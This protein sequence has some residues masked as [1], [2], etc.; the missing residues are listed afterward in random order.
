MTHRPTTGA[1]NRSPSPVIC[2]TRRSSGV[3]MRHRR[4]PPARVDQPARRPG[5]AVAASRA[6]DVDVPGQREA[7]ERTALDAVLLAAGGADEAK[8]CRAASPDRDDE[9]E[10]L[11]AS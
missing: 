7:D 5:L 6:R 3:A 10:T 1:R 9:S 11:G 2:R 8:L 4:R